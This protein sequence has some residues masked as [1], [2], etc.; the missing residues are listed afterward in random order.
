MYRRPRSHLFCCQHLDQAGLN[1]AASKIAAGTY[2]GQFWHDDGNLECRSGSIDNGEG[3][4]AVTC[5]TA[6]DRTHCSCYRNKWDAHCNARPDCKTIDEG[7][8]I[9]ESS[10]TCAAKFARRSLLNCPPTS[11][12]Q[13]KDVFC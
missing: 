12:R 2:A 6:T 10:G 3:Q 9:S 1:D 8:G 13:S 5:D 7:S 11:N 4:T